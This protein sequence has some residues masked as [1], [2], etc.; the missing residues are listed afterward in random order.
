MGNLKNREVISTI[1]SDSFIGRA[2]DLAV[3][4][5]HA[6]GDSRYNG[7]AVLSEPGLGLSELLRQSY[8]KLFYDQNDLVPFYFQFRKGDRTPR[9]MAVRFLQTFMQQTVAFRRND[10]K[11]L[12]AKSDICE[13][14]EL[15]VP[16]DG[17]WMDRL[18]ETCTAKSALND[19][20]SFVRQALSAPLRA[21]SHGTN[22]F[23]MI[24]EIDKAE[25]ITNG[26]DLVEEIKEI[27]KRSR[28]RHVFAGKR[29]F[30][31]KA[32]QTGDSKLD[33]I[34]TFRLCK[35]DF[36]KCG[37]LAES[38]A[39]QNNLNITDQTRD[40]ITEQFQRNTSLIRS[41]FGEAH[42]TESDL[43][44]FQLVEK[45]YSESIF[46]GRIK[47]FYD[48]IFDEVIPDIEIQ[49]QFVGLLYNSLVVEKAETPVENWRKRVDLER[50]EFYRAIR[51]LNANEIVRQ[52]SN[53]VE[54]MT[55]NDVLCDYV[56]ARYRLEISGDARSLVIA[57]SLV[58]FLKKAPNTMAKLY[59]GN[60][61]IGLRE[62]LSVF[63]CQK[64]PRSLL[65]YASFKDKLKGTE[66][67]EMLEAAK[68]EAEHIT[69]PQIVYT[70]HTVSLYSPI[71]KL[72]ETD[73][74]A[75]A[76][77]FEA[78]DYKDENEVVWIVAEIDSKLEATDELTAFWCDRLEMVSLMC[79][80]DN[81][82][83]WLISPEGF[84]PD[85]IETL[86]QRNALGS[87]RKQVELLAKYLDVEE[88]VAQQI[89]SNEYEMVVPMG[90]D[91]EL[92]AAYAVEEIARKHSF[93]TKAI[94]QI[95]TALVEACINATEHSHSPDRK[96]Y[97][98][99]A[100]EDDKIVI[101]I[102]NRGLRF[103][104]KEIKEIKPDDDR[105]GWGLK[106]MRS[107]MDDVKF[108]QVDDGTRISMTKLLKQNG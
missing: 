101:T 48:S 104:G 77:G 22:V 7:L 36:E 41:I 26:F 5:R 16:S 108:E 61:A 24:D 57:E 40:L 12:E 23:V 56:S 105:R 69:L 72:A 8:D 47:G 85:A 78:A 66:F 58:E 70:A 1:R 62:L 54:I 71:S 81:Y 103:K 9:Q 45:V 14:A 53:M 20:N 19:D 15:A 6:N 10:P 94:N 3:I 79:D 49:K 31:F 73:R 100:V 87:S 18:I 91:T 68:N 32:M 46:G 28:V 102:S 17:E 64:I 98:K 43:D 25:F 37:E 44:T 86:N 38:L 67:E 83:L 4:L 97:Q 39:S 90:D 82:R 107:L 30:L 42:E 96:I 89:N 74:S 50:K 84:T 80:F 34:E 60:S 95:K 51:L 35:L 13:I 93:D 99:F 92:I 29:R 27:Y 33:E 65:D 21:A 88:A 55:E 2:N 63:D 76:L 75:V 11:I 52:T 106:L 59:R